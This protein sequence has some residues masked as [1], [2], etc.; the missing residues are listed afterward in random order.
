M[1]KSIIILI[2]ILLLNF[3]TFKE[4]VGDYN[5][6]YVIAKSGLLCRKEPNGKVIHKLPYGTEVD[7][8]DSTNIELTINDDG[9]EIRGGWVKIKVKNSNKTGYVFDGFLRSGW[10][11]DPQKIAKLT[12]SS[13]LKSSNPNGLLLKGIHNIYDINLNIIRQININKI[14]DVSIL[15]VTKFDRP[16]TKKTIENYWEEH[17]EWGK[18]LKIKYQNEE[19]ILFG[20]NI[21]QINSTEQKI[22]QTK[23]INFVFAENFL[24]NSRTSIHELSGCFS[25]NNILIKSDNNYSLIYN[26]ESTKEDILTFFDNDYGSEDISSLII[27]KDT[28]YSK[29]EQSFQEGIGEYKLKIF[30]N[31]TNWEFIKY[32]KK[33]DYQQD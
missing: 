13:F 19:I 11:L 32:D 12:L 8:I 22:Y 16:E 10:E 9:K 18:Y 5:G 29:V 20:R 30:N 2:S 3:D 15:S 25:V 4:N 1:K 33:R 17:C 27:K 24:T 21:L 6:L 14:S 31:K 26:S 7:I 28:I 23:N